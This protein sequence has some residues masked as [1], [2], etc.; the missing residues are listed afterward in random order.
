MRK[1]IS[2]ISGLVAAFVLTGASVVSR[3]ARG[4]EPDSTVRLASEGFHTG[5][6]GGFAVLPIGGKTI[7]VVA[8]Q[9]NLG[10]GFGR[11]ELR[12]SPTFFH[13][14]AGA[15][16]VATGGFVAFEGRIN[17]GSRFAMGS[18][19]VLGYG[20][21]DGDSAVLVG[22][23]ATPFAVRFGARRQFE[24]GLWGT[25]LLAGDEAF[26]GPVVMF[27]ALWP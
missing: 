22:L 6:S 15:G 20:A 19:P 11:Y 3:S 23:T 13:A 12:L 21:A 2:R 9:V 26:G 7:P 27:T 24:V 18:G 4:H 14:D 10:Y 1:Q 17:L 5:V 16:G 25:I 8:A